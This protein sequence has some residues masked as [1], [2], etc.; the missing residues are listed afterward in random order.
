MWLVF[1]NQ[2]E[3]LRLCWGPRLNLFIDWRKQLTK[4]N[5]RK[6]VKLSEDW[7][8]YNLERAVPHKTVPFSMRQNSACTTSQWFLFAVQM[9]YL[10][11]QNCF[12]CIRQTKLYCLQLPKSTISSE[13]AHFSR[14]NHKQIS[15]NLSIAKKNFIYI[16]ICIE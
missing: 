13:N 9:P 4:F 12:S 14:R 7:S 5:W 1:D 11:R 16:Y 2:E 6:F 3:V 10:R 15:I 8:D